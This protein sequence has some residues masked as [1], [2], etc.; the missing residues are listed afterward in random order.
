M[1]GGGAFDRR[2][3]EHRA[4][5]CLRSMMLDIAGAPPPKFR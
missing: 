4:E 3:R 5:P 2:V 1:G